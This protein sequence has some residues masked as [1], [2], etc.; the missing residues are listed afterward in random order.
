MGVSIYTVGKGTTADGNSGLGFYFIK[1]NVSWRLLLGCQLIPGS[2]MLAFSFWMP[3]S[4]RYLAYVERFDE[5]LEVLKKMHGDSHDST[6][7]LREYNQ[8]KAQIL[9]DK[10]ERLGMK[11]I[12]TK[13]S[14]RKRFLLV[15][16]YAIAC[17]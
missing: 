6:F 1:G 17:M 9:L 2:L 11:A 13:P 7:Y 15:F 4:P 14:Y 8:I 10:Q 16:W 5:T 3:E 12:W